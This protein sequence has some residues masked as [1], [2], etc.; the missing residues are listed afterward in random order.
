MKLSNV[1][2]VTI[3]FYWIFSRANESSAHAMPAHELHSIL[4]FD[5]RVIFT[6]Q[7]LS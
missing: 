3:Y 6:F 5:A 1:K 7:E 2:N 4:L